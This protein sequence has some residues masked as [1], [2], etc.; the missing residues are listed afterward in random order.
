MLYHVGIT[1]LCNLVSIRI[2]IVKASNHIDCCIYYYCSF[3]VYFLTRLLYYSYSTGL[4]SRLVCQ[5]PS[6]FGFRNGY[7]T[8]C[9]GTCLNPRLVHR[10]SIKVKYFVF[11]HLIDKMY[12]NYW[13][14]FFRQLIV[15]YRLLNSFSFVYF[16][17]SVSDLS[18][19]RYSNRFLVT[20]YFKIV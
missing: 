18:R 14:L 2:S 11:F 13:L 1:S 17:I 7:C 3:S 9:Y 19:W 4:I 15:S 12:S 10:I 5:F 16:V 8:K 6:Y 20:I